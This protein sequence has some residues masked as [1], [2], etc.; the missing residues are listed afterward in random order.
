VPFDAT[1][2]AFW[3]IRHDAITDAVIFETAPRLE[4]GSPG[5]WV[6]RGRIARAFALTAVRVE[7]K[8]GTWQRETVAPGSGTFDR[9]KVVR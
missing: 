4:D 2:H 5:G 9:V 8:A 3:R 7:L 1:A 6:E